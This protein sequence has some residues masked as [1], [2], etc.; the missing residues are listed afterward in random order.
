GF[1]NEYEEI[2]S[3]T[4]SAVRKHLLEGYVDGLGA[5]TRHLKAQGLPR[6]KSHVLLPYPDMKPNEI[7]APNY[8]NGETVVLVRHPHGG[9]FEIPEL[10]VNNK[11][12]KARK[13]IGNAMD[14]VGIH[15][16]RAQ[17]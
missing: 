16:S 14:A 6:T 17:K 4:N 13:Q 8:R 7:Y 1:Q 9:T 15:P 2:M 10:I 3:L 12:P 11:H 5:K